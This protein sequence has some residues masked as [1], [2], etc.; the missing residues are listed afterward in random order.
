M[1]KKHD[2][3]KILAVGER[4]FRENGY[5]NTG[6]EEILEKA[7][8]PRSSFYHHFK[9]KEGFGVKAVEYYGQHVKELLSGIMSDA[10]TLSPTERLKKYYYMI[11][12]YNEA[13]VFGSCCLV[14][15]MSIDAGEAP[16]VIQEEARDQYA[17]WVEVVS[18]CVKEGQDQ[19]EIRTDM[20]SEDVAQL[21]FQTVYGAF[22]IGRL[23]RDP[24]ELEKRMNTTFR[25]IKA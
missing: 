20:P 21:L 22:T 18:T 23:T 1:N 6:T 5:H 12:S 24:K 25:L 11:S 8:Y 14:Q 13:S 2:K 7:A 17:Q 19:G 15:R 9:N 16:G 4:L 3:E 10:D